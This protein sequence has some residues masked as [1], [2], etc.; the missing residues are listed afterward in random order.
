MVKK[1]SVARKP[2]AS[3]KRAGQ[4]SARS[5]VKV[6]S[7]ASPIPVAKFQA[8]FGAVIGLFMGPFFAL[9]SF[10][11]EPPFQSFDLGVWWIFAIPV[12]FAVLSFLL[13][14]IGVY[15]YNVSASVVGGMAVEFQ[16]AALSSVRRLGV[17]SLAKINAFQFLIF[18]VLF[19]VLFFAASVLGSGFGIGSLLFL[20]LVPLL[21]A[22]F[23]FVN[24]A[25]SAFFY[26]IPARFVGGV[27]T[28]FQASGGKHVLARIGVLSAGLVNMVMTSF[29]GLLVG[30]VYMAII[31]FYLSLLSPGA[32]IIGF[33]VGLLALVFI[34]LTNAASGF[35]VGVML[36]ALYNLMAKKLGGFKVSFK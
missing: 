18:G 12:L 15:L 13:G 16:D 30:F 1:K 36:A 34:V 27:K 25:L 29:G 33:F 4:V 8:V 10:T 19:G 23:G 22:L 26:N 21:A 6:L 28:D 24:G 7:W 11:G 3:S 32:I 17:L 5:S 20:I 2:G 9:M 14:L 35:V 31:M